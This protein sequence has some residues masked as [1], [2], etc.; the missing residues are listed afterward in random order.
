MDQ[1]VYT[2]K[3]YK[4]NVMMAESV[5]ALLFSPEELIRKRL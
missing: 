3:Y 1:S 5:T 4:M 2:E